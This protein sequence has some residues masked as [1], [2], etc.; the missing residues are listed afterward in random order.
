[1]SRHSKI[2]QNVTPNIGTEAQ[3]SF[4]TISH[5]LLANELLGDIEEANAARPHGWSDP[6]DGLQGQ[7]KSPW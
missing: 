1:M 5:E 6:V 2:W 7:A 3:A 4:A